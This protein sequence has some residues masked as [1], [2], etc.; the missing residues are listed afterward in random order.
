MKFLEDFKTMTIL[1]PMTT[2]WIYVGFE[3]LSPVVMK[4]SIY[5]DITPC[6]PLKFIRRLGGTYRFHLQK[7][8]MFFW[9]VGWVSANYAALYSREDNILQTELTFEFC[10]CIY[11]YPSLM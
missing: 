7:V 4:S 1:T 8:D 5:W 11:E 9:N 3:V 10:V 6:S 2:N